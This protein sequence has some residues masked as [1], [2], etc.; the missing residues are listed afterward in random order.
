MISLK[1]TL[2]AV[3]DGRRVTISRADAD[4]LLAEAR[5]DDLTELR[6]RI[7]SCDVYVEDR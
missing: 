3:A 2:Q 6:Q 7:R 1:D 4:R 5:D